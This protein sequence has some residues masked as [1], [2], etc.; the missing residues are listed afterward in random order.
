MKFVG[1]I[2]CMSLLWMAGCQKE[3]ADIH[4]PIP[5]T[6][7]PNLAYGT[8]AKQKMDVYLP[9]NRSLDT[10]KS[11]ILIHGGAWIEGDKSDFND[12]M[13]AIKN[14]LPGWAIFNLNYRLADTLTATNIFPAQEMD[15]KKALEFIHAHRTSYQISQKFVLLG[16]SAGAHLAQLQAYKYD[17]PIQP[18]ALVS[19]FGP[20]NMEDMYYHPASP[21]IPTHFI[22]TIVGGTPSTAPDKYVQSSP[23][24]FI[25]AQSPPTISFQGGLDFLVNPAQQDS[26]HAKLDA[27]QVINEKVFYP[28]EGHGWTGDKLLE[29]LNRVQAFLYTHVP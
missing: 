7:H 5:E 23:I 1:I 25:H 20:C 18:K 10:T 2:L 14:T 3:P 17:T 29:T 28:L 9:A 24:H 8:D 21:F 6:F 19:L 12:L 13:D 27:F 16:A 11:I 22:Q 4:P 15:I 26:L